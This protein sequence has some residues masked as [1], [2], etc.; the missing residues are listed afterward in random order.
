[1][2][3]DTI[4]KNLTDGMSRR[5]MLAGMRAA[6]ALA[7]AGIAS[8]AHAQQSQAGSSDAESSNKGG[9]PTEPDPKNTSLA[10]QNPD[11]FDA[12][13]TD[14]GDVKSFK[15]PFD[16][17]HNKISAGGW[18]RQVTVRDLP[19]STTMAGVNM[20]LKKGAVRELHWHVSAEWAFMITGNA[21]VTAVDSDS[22][23]FVDDLGPGDLWY[24]P[25]GIPHSIQGTGD[26][27]CE[28]LLV[29]DD[30]NFSEFDTFLISDWMSHT[31]PSVLSKNFDNAP[32]SAFA[33]LPRHELY[34]FNAPMPASLEEDRKAATGPQ[35]VVPTPFTFK[36]SEAKAD[37]SHAGGEV[38]IVDSHSFPASTTVAAALVTL[39][40]G[41][42]RELHWHPN[43]D[44]WQ[45]Y[46]KGKG[47]MTVFTGGAKARTMDMQV[48]DVGYVQQSLGHYIENTG[49]E[50]LV[51]LEMFKSSYY[52]DISL[53]Q[54][55]AHLP[56]ELVEAHLHLP[57]QVLAAI[58]KQ[59][60]VVVP[61]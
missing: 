1:M 27:G 35:G 59:K 40:P 14:A 46:V 20:R 58:P 3:A 37:V 44:E 5:R 21:R 47:R 52:Q 11:S 61:V 7:T 4:Q 51:F 28:F 15:Y 29:F 17:A 2:D 30:G 12:P 39:K 25:S 49:N 19:I 16:L 6:A 32:E 24:F 9:R 10:E 57:E 36:L 54:W 55:I 8:V 42:L 53:G 45:Y 22:K 50:D 34:I 26:D 43:A 33:R 23:A 48:G 31:P 13:P 56:P 41:G 18:A 60:L 38:K